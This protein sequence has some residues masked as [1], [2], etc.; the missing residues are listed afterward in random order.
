MTNSFDD[1]G[2]T[3]DKIAGREQAWLGSHTLFVDGDAAPAAIG[4]DRGGEGGGESA[5]CTEQGEEE[6]AARKRRAFSLARCS[7]GA[8]PADRQDDADAGGDQNEYRETDFVLC[9]ESTFDPISEELA[10]VGIRK[11]DG[12]EP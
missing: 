9:R 12:Q 1:R 3:F 5:A 8:R 4:N 11:G 6:A 2:C 7:R 10:E